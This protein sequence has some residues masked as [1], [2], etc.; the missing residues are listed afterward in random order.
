MVN[1]IVRKD[2]LEDLEDVMNNN[3]RPG[4]GD[5]DVNVFA[6]EYPVPYGLLVRVKK[7]IER[8]RAVNA[9]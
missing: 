9:A 2:V 8:L 3:M 5:S 7:E 4:T 1:R 6:I